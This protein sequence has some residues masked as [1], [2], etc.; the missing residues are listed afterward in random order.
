MINSEQFA[1]HR[2]ETRLQHLT[3]SGRITPQLMQTYSALSEA[4]AE[5]QAKAESRSDIEIHRELVGMRA[6]PEGVVFLL[7]HLDPIGDE[8]GIE[9]VAFE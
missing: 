2:H 8:V 3:R 5:P 4:L 1:G 9:D 6:Q 7:F